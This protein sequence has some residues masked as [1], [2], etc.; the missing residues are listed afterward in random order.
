MGRFG[1]DKHSILAYFTFIGGN[2][3]TRMS[4]KQHVATR[5]NAEVEYKGMTLRI[6][7]VLWIKL[8]LSVLGIKH[9][10]PM[11]LFRNNKVARDIAHNLV[12]QD[13]TKHVKVDR[14]FIKEKLE[15]KIIE[16]STIRTEN[17]LVY[18]IS[19]AISS[20][21]YFRFLDKL[22]MRNVYAPT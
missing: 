13:R 20:H 16:V 15:G 19:K 21:K 8:L 17:Q 2:L 9:D 22:G 1:D 12:Q 10:P 11:K 5:S 3:V 4:E 18:I 6:C 7:A 14:F